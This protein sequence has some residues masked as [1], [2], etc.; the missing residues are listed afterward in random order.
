MENFRYLDDLIHSGAKEISL[1]SDIVLD[2]DEEIEYLEGI[3]LDV[4]G[5]VI[6]GNGHSIDACGNALIFHNSSNVAIKDLILKNGIGA[7][8]NFKGT[9]NISGSEL[10]SNMSEIAGGAI[11]NYWGEVNISDSKL[12]ENVSGCHGGAI[13]NFN[14][15]VNISGSEFSGNFA[16][17]DGGAIFNGSNLSIGD[18]IFKGNT[19]NGSGGALYDNRG[20]IDIKGSQ[21][22]GNSSKGVFGGG[23]IHKNRGALKISD[24]NLSG[25]FAE[26][27]GGAIFAIDC[28]LVLERDVIDD[29]SSG[30]GAVHAK[31]MQSMVL[32]ECEFE[33]NLQI[34]VFESEG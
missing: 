1:D 13:F 10:A 16:E 26:S 2:E 21:F 20:E 27:D 24:S 18:C 15:T 7:I 32:K 3:R 25:N 14:G 11:Y 28:E 23:A 33:N 31:I 6:N 19:S 8:Y 34:D 22:L 30:G 5:L 9:L 4:D 17:S 29:N 12:L